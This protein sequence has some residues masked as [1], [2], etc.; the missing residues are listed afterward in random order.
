MNCH[1]LIDDEV[2]GDNKYYTR[3]NFGQLEGTEENTG[4]IGRGCREFHKFLRASFAGSPHWT[5]HKNSVYPDV[6]FDICETLP[7]STL[8]ATTGRADCQKVASVTHSKISFP[9]SEPLVARHSK[10]QDWILL[11]HFFAKAW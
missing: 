5:T 6:R 4:E 1:R 7:A 11:L 9:N 2:M 10:Y 8:F 3:Q